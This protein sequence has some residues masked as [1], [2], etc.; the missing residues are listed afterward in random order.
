MN[1]TT[2]LSTFAR[3]DFLIQEVRAGELEL[4]K[5]A[6]GYVWR[7]LGKPDHLVELVGVASKE[8]DRPWVFSDVTDAIEHVL[9]CSAKAFSGDC[10]LHSQLSVG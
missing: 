8:G 1:E 4:R 2:T 10:G 6:A 9:A 3:W 7:W 5:S